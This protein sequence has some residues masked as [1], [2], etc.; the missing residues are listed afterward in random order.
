MYNICAAIAQFLHKMAAGDISGNL[1]NAHPIAAVASVY[2]NVS[3]V[4]A[5][6]SRYSLYRAILGSR[7]D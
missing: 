3:I 4:Y 5:A 1:Q 7:V 6:S 2:T